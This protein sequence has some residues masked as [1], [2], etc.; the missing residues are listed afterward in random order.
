MAG[1]PTGVKTSKKKV[2]LYSNS[3]NAHTAIIVSG[4][5]SH[6]YLFDA[7]GK[8]IGGA[9]VGYISESLIKNYL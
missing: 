3:L 2:E 7:W 5:M 9:L 1:A 4:E 6:Y 8:Q